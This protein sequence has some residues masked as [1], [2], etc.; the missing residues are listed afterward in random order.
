MPQ[1]FQISLSSMV[2]LQ[3]LAHMRISTCLSLTIF[4]HGLSM[5]SVK[6]MH[7]SHARHVV[8][9]PLIICAKSTCV[10]FGWPREPPNHMDM[11]LLDAIRC[12]LDLGK[13]PDLQVG[14]GMG[15]GC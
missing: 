6:R 13:T 9:H 11:V 14:Y 5:H 4:M 1:R 10:A 15:L 8:E 7:W 2:Q 12:L 3:Y